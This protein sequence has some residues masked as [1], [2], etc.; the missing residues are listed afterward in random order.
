MLESFT[1]YRRHLKQVTY[2][3]L[4]HT[5]ELL[6]I[7]WHDYVPNVEVLNRADMPSVEA[8]L[9]SAN[10]R[11]AGHVV[12]MDDSRLPKAVMYAE[13]LARMQ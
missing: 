4:W 2:V 13:F 9:V 12:R 5:R 1:L 10:L 3:Q 6:N 11:W 8:L 7:K